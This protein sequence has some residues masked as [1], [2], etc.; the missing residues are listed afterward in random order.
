M[1]HGYYFSS[2]G[3]KI[4]FTSVIPF[5]VGFIPS[6]KN[7]NIF[8]QQKKKKTFDHIENIKLGSN[9]VT[10]EKQHLKRE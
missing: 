7:K 6:D 5:A 1:D 8:D 3:S 2:V 9:Q 10:D 4:L